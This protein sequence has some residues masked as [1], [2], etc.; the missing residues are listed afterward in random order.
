M[1]RPR[2]AGQ[3]IQHGSEAERAAARFSRRFE[4]KLHCHSAAGAIRY[5]AVTM[6]MSRPATKAAFAS[7]IVYL[8]PLLLPHTL[9]F[10]GG[11]LAAGAGR[12]GA[13]WVAADL[14]VAL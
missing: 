11:S 9:M 13:S 8:F 7:F 10:Y 1:S 6:T 5:H 2:E 14:A 3:E 12:R 4:V